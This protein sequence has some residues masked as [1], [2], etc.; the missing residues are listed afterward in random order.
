VTPGAGAIRTLFYRKKTTVDTEWTSFASS[1]DG[2]LE[3]LWDREDGD[4]YLRA[5]SVTASG[6]CSGID[7]VAG[8]S[9]FIA[10]SFDEFGQDY[11]TE[12]YLTI[13]TASTSITSTSAPTL[14]IYF[15]IVRVICNNNF[16]DTDISGFEIWRAESPTYSPYTKV[17]E[18]VCDNSLA[19]VVY[20]DEST[21]YGKTYKYK[22]KKKNTSGT[23]SGFSA[24]SAAVTTLQVDTSS[25]ANLAITNTKI[26][27]N[28]IESPMI[29]ANAICSN[30]LI[31]GELITLSAQIKNAIILNAHI[32]NI[33]ADKICAGSISVGSYIDGNYTPGS[34]GWRIHGNGSAEFSNVTVRGAV[35][36]S[37][38][39]FCSCG[40]MSSP[41]MVLN[42]TLASESCY[43]AFVLTSDSVFASNFYT[44]KDVAI[45]V[46]ARGY[47]VSAYSSVCVA[48]N[49][50][51]PACA[52]SAYAT[53]SGQAK[54][55]V[56]NAVA[57]SH[58]ICAVSASYPSIEVNNGICVTNGGIYVTNGGYPSL[59]VANGLKTTSY[60]DL[61][62]VTSITDSLGTWY[63]IWAQS[64]NVVSS[65]TTK[66]NFTE[67]SVLDAI[68]KLEITAWQRT[69]STPGDETW[70][71]GPMAEDVKEHLGLGTGKT[72]PGLDGVALKGI[73]ELAIK[74]ES[75]E[76]IIY[77]MQTKINTLTG[78][79]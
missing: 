19:S 2:Q 61:G 26:C 12:G 31:T 9:H 38:G 64:F 43:P 77:D 34:A 40:N 72:I 29:C 47:A 76:A 71:I 73:Q 49:G 22:T 66:K 46:S 48:V 65:R 42:N 23:V 3:Y 13:A 32:A 30:H 56:A 69:N 33:T 60:N 28:S 74:I 24:E 8:D 52:I 63:G 44:S 53:S 45:N 15:K 27:A 79:V 16:L 17:G 75:L 41:T 18:I 4:Y 59:C 57:G 6:T 58:A 10:G 68:R 37:S 21:D 25:I 5:V 36:A 51:S 62:G 1:V 78:A 67:V 39:S 11:T 50:Q 20:L 7:I 70:Q 54:A 14:G 55:L 35:Y